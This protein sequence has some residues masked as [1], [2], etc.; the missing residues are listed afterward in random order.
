LDI[1]TIKAQMAGV[2]PIAIPNNVTIADFVAQ[3]AA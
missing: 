2:A 1:S 3:K